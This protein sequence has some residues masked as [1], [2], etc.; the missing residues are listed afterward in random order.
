M[1]EFK[2]WKGKKIFLI[3]KSGRKYAG[4]I[5]ET[6]DNFLFILDKYNEK[7]T[8]SISEIASMEEEQ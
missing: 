4:V 5:K 6:T 8:V 3:T 2:D 7:V 1:D